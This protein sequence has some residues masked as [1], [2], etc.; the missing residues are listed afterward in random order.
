MR[1]FAK[2]RKEKIMNTIEE[3]HVRNLKYLVKTYD[4]LTDVLKKT[5][6]RLATINPDSVERYESGKMKLTTQPDLKDFHNH[7]E[8]IKT[9]M[10]KELKKYNI[11]TEWLAN[12]KGIGANIAANLV[13]LYYYKFQP[14]CQEC[15]AN[16]YFEKDKK[17]CDHCGA[18][19]KKGLLKYRIEDKD[20]ANISKWW[21][22]MGQGCDED[23]KKAH[24]VDGES[25]GYSDI[26]RAITWQI[27][28]QFVKH[29]DKKNQV[30][31]CKYREFYDYRK[32]KRE[33]T[34]ANTTPKHRHNMACH[35]SA[36]VFLAHFWLVARTLDRKPLT[37]PYK[38]K[39]Y[40]DK[41]FYFDRFETDENLDRKL[42]MTR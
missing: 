1:N 34:H 12:I 19:F 11:Y 40:L 36:K 21:S 9:K 14:I 22:Y 28:Q 35:E 42:A 20:F 13:I 24:R 29:W 25:C 27:S 3:L 39:W 31:T 26:G 41:P 4:S 7:R 8:R 5:K 16:I 23:G 10:I 37:K 6:Q 33:K 32:A 17:K 30:A 18:S 38:S 2:A 15:G